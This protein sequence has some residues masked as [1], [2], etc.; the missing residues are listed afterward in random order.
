MCGAE[1]SDTVRHEAKNLVRQIN[2][3]HAAPRS[4]HA[5][6]RHPRTDENRSQFTVSFS[7]FSEASG[8]NQPAQPSGRTKQT[9]HERI[10]GNQASYTNQWRSKI[11]GNRCW[12]N[13][14][15]T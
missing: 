10:L 7:L 6:R 1:R 11:C 8:D 9:R 4:R 5:R 15:M 3:Q 14:R 2:Q 12:I 13:R